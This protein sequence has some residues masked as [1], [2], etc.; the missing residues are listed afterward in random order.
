MAGSLSLALRKKFPKSIIRGY[1]RSQESFRK[2]KKLKI[3]NEL[4]RDY[5]QTLKGANLVV[6]GL[7]V[8]VIPEYLKLIGPYL[9]PGAV[10]FDL[11]SSK[12]K[13]EES[14]KELPK[15]VSFVG[16]HPLCGSEKSGARF[17]CE[18]LYKNSL[19]LIT[20][21]PKNRA[22]QSVKRLWQSLGARVM[23]MSPAQHDK[24]LSATSHLPHLISFSLS[25]AIDD[26][27]LKFCAGSFRDL[28]RISSSGAHLWKD[29]FISNKANILKD[30]NGFIKILKEFE[31]ALKSGNK[32]GLGSLI[33]Q[34]NKKH[35]LISKNSNGNSNRRACR[36]G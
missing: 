3:V 33:K 13:I 4:F 18:K 1:A 35:A 23:F 12:L 19:C 26:K 14:A 28:T 30:L 24:I 17:S 7:P 2:L 31:K 9:K 29:I 27:F 25:K 5:R 11:G 15:K 8:E 21:S 6:L 32:A 36:I 34:A 22:A 10:V 16:C 20:A